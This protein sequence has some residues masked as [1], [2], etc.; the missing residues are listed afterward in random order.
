MT[1]Y[2]FLTTGD[3]EI[4]VRGGWRIIPGCSCKGIFEFGDRMAELQE[5]LQG[6]PDD[7]DRPIEALY[8]EHRRFAWLCDR[9]LELNGIDADWVRPSDLGWLLFGHRGEDGKAVASPLLVLNA[10]AEQRYPRKPSDEKT[11]NDYIS[12]IAAIFAQGGSMEEAFRVATS[13]PARLVLGTLEDRA[14]HS[15]SAEQK[16][17]TRFKAWAGEQREQ[18]QR[19]Q[20][21]GWGKQQRPADLPRVKAKA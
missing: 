13:E 9:T 16:D 5:L 8:L 7:D 14:W 10:A 12:L 20:A 11:H 3:L 2:K 15:M 19:Q 1:T 18:A 21:G 17:D 4:P 6:L